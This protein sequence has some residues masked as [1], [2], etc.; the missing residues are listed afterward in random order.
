MT[1][2]IKFKIV[3]LTLNLCFCALSWAEPIDAKA[4][5]KLPELK[6]V[7]SAV[8]K[9]NALTSEDQK[10][11]IQCL[12]SKNPALISIAAWI[13][14][15]SKSPS[16]EVL[17]KMNSLDAAKLSEMPC[18]FVKISTDKVNA[19]LKKEK[20]SASE[21]L[22][23]SNNIYLKIETIRENLTTD[24]EKNKQVLRE[25]QKD[26][27]SKA[28]AVAYHLAKKHGIDKSLQ[29][30]PM[31]DERYELVLSIIQGE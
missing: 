11:L 28:K 13:V 18:A 15:E 27:S 29:P 8:R 22:K 2:N 23:D 24:P 7:A 3:I 4:G 1:K 12:E 19:R 30:Y 26:E 25:L 21:E 31:F 17:Q 14:G 10:L 9:G 5:E 20:W 16:S 6:R